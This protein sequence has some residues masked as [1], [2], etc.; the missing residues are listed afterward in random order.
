M[1]IIEIGLYTSDWSLRFARANLPQGG[2]AA[3]PHVDAGIPAVQLW[4]HANHAF[5]GGVLS[6][7]SRIYVRSHIGCAWRSVFRVAMLHRPNQ[8]VY[9][10]HAHARIGVMLQRSEQRLPDVRIPSRITE[11]FHSLHAHRGVLILA[12]SSDQRPAHL[13]IPRGCLE[14]LK[15]IETD[16]GVEALAIFHDVGQDAAY[17]A[18]IGAA[19]EHHR[20]LG[21]KTKLHV[22]RP[23]IRGRR[24]IDAR[25]RHVI[26]LI[27]RDRR[28][29]RNVHGL[30]V[31]VAAI[32]VLQ[33]RNNLS[34]HNYSKEDQQSAA[35]GWTQGP[36]APHPTKRTPVFLHRTVQKS[37]KGSAKS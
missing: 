11:R 36:P 9:G 28:L 37:V 27:S 26:Q 14:R 20:L 15:A 13:L 8:H 34:F 7:A 23:S 6:R 25:D 24:K 32:A 4:Q 10:F 30:T 31:A 16:T 5:H 21:T 18:I 22:R 1:F 29:G 33:P 17:I 35:P 12:R 3:H 2:G 19:G